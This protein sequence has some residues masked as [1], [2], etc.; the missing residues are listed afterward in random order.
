MGAGGDARSDGEEEESALRRKTGWLLVERSSCI[1]PTFALSGFSSALLEFFCYF[2]FLYIMMM[3][4][5]RALCNMSVSL[6]LLYRAE[7]MVS[8]SPYFLACYEGI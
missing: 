6:F 1:S 8:T 2:F 3:G 4:I 5:S 7:D